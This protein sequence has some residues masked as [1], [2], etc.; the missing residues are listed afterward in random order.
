MSRWVLGRRTFLE[1][2][3]TLLIFV[4]EEAVRAEGLVERV[5]SVETHERQLVWNRGAGILR[6]KPA[7]TKSRAGDRRH[8]ERSRRG[9]GMR[10]SS[11]ADGRPPR[12]SCFSQP[13]RLTLGPVRQR[14]SSVA[15]LVIVT[16]STNS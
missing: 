13:T 8:C 4:E 10:V 1:A 15:R 9:Q 14:I 5:R 12:G 6:M 11:H 3:R 2:C 7:G 16:G